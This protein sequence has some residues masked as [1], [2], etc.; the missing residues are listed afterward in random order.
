MSRTTPLPITTSAADPRPLIKQIGDAIRLLIASGELPVGAQLPSVRGLA[1]QL[2][3]NHNTVAKA[4]GDLVA[5]GWLVARQ[6]L[7]LFVA[8][9]RQRMSDEER[10]HR[11]QRA[12][13]TLTAE[14]IGLG[15]SV[16]EVVSAVRSS[17]TPCLGAPTKRSGA[18]A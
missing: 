3:I 14:V 17:L 16:E 15:Y 6:G 18:R 10:E 2:C 4:Y 9:R 11:L 8:A 7:G 1:Q 5:E 13:D 12:V